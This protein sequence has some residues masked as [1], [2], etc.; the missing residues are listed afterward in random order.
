MATETGKEIFMKSKK[1][2]PSKQ[3]ISLLISSKSAVMVHRQWPKS[4]EEETSNQDEIIV[5]SNRKVEL[6]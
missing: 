2:S 4:M 5:E 3:K 6:V 1:I